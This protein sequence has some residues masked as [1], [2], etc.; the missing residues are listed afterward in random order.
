MTKAKRE[1]KMS[2]QTVARRFVHVLRGAGVERVYGVGDH[3]LAPL[4]DA[5]ERADGIDWA[6]TRD[7]QAGVLAAANE[8]HAT[9]RLAVCVGSYG[10]GKMH[11][12]RGLRDAHRKGEPVLALASRSSTDGLPDGLLHEIRPEQLFAEVSCY[13]GLVSDESQLAELTPTAIQHA[14]VRADVS[15][16][17]LNPPTVIRHLSDQSAA[18]PACGRG[19]RSRQRVVRI[20]GH[21]LHLTCAVDRRR[22]HRG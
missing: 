7:E 22:R 5:L 16:L 20:H 8:A 11:L 4:V 12:I 17:L 1:I 10:A 6:E 18:C 19:I 13:C 15:V 9:G 14:L 3:T 2:D 21:Q